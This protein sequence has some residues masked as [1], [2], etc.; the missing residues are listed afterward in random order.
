MQDKN[1]EHSISGLY[2]PKTREWGG[3]LPV[4]LVFPEQKSLAL[5][6][7]GWQAVYRLLENEGSFLV[8][9]F[10]WD[11]KTGRAA[12]QDSDNKL[13][14]FP[15]ICFSLNFEGDYLNLIQSLEAEE[16]EPCA[17]NRNHWP[18]IMAGGPV[19]FINPFPVMPS[20]DFIYAGEAEDSFICIARALKNSFLEGK[21]RRQALEAIAGFPGIYMSGQ[22]HRVSRQ[23][24]ASDSRRLENPAYS[25]FVSGQSV[26]R[27]SFLVEIN[28]GCP[29]GCRF[30]AAGFVYR[31]GRTAEMQELKDLISG[32]RPGKVGLVGTSLTDW[33]DLEKFLQWLKAQKIK[34]SLSS[35]RSDGLSQHFLEFL[36]RSGTR[37]ITLAVE[38]ISRNLRTAV[39]KRFDQEKFLQGVEEISRLQF[40]TLKL[41]FILG[42]PG[43]TG[44]DFQELEIFLEEIQQAR[45][46]GMGNRKK[47]IGLIQ[48]SASMFVPK[49]WTP[50]QWSPMVSR[51]E[52]ES[53]CRQF[54]KL[55]SRHKAI[56]FSSENPFQARIQG[57]LARGDEHVHELLL[58]A[59]E[60]Q[61]NWKKALAGW[62]R[63]ITHYADRQIS[64]EET[65][66]WDR[67]D[68]GVK[69]EYLKRE[70][71][72]YWQGRLTPPCPD[73]E[74]SNCRRCGMQE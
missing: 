5:S 62:S 15:L 11:H 57:L 71:Q 38:G 41:Y 24:A 45:F 36:R 47:G 39:N 44:K 40:N 25:V 19:T 56:K 58:L 6:T 12:N 3:K 74:C 7:L 32:M 10:F 54:K 9:R 64:L 13:S 17:S 43:E 29:H 53:R 49:P 1:R 70:W 35:M 30:C 67:L 65:L 4:A 34:F 59:A 21:G 31:P 22:K 50:L 20:L 16:I 33:P 14:D 60:N 52:F 48:I 68:I 18:L 72:K 61:G 8:Q 27:D 51:Q 28:R 69:K 23:V 37:S 26:F 66:P 2:R 73:T 42:L 55:C 46:K 63:D